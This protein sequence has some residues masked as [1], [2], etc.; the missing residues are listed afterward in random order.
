MDMNIMNPANFWQGKIVCL[1]AIEPDDAE[2]FYRWNLDSERARYLDFVWPPTSMESVRTW[3]H[4]QTRKK[5]VN[6]SYHW[7]I[8]NMSGEAVGSI[9]TH[10]CDPHNGTFSYGVDIVQEHR[11]NGY[12]GEAIRIVLKYYFR[13]LRY[14][15]ATIPVHAD[16]P[17]SIRLHEKLNFKLEGRLRR[18]VYTQGDYVDVLWFGMTAEEYQQYYYGI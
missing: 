10:D 6:D 5:L 15:K 4:E 7:V 12:A 11:G 14:Q 8:Q 3:V 1:R 17:A 13:E 18:M 9:S 2:L 16:N